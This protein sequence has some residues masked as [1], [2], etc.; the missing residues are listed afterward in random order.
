MHQNHKAIDLPIKLLHSL[1]ALYL[2][3]SPGTEEH[4]VRDSQ[5]RLQQ[6]HGK[7][8]HKPLRIVNSYQVND[9][10]SLQLPE[11]DTC[12]I[13]SLGHCTGGSSRISNW[14]LILWQVMEKVDEGKLYTDLLYRYQYMCK[15]MNFDDAD[16][17]L[18][19]GIHR[20]SSSNSAQHLV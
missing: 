8:L 13:C 7:L 12:Y 16:V 10:G 2:Y 17:K 15:F 20:F 19:H 11:I 9:R 5:E 4:N 14:T 6:N 1:L 3:N 18:I